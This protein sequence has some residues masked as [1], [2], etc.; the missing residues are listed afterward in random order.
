MIYKQ[1]YSM[2]KLSQ[3]EDQHKWCRNCCILNPEGDLWL[4]CLSRINE[5]GKRMKDA[6]GVEYEWLLLAGC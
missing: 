1:F 6:E 3:D 5:A 4:K 2:G